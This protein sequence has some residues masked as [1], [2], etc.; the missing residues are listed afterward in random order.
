[1]QILKGPRKSV[2]RLAFSPDGRWLAVGGRQYLNLWDLPTGR[3]VHTWQLQH[4]CTGLAFSPDQRLLA[5]VD[6]EVGHDGRAEL[7]IW[8][9][10][11]PGTPVMRAADGGRFLW[12]HP[13]GSWLLVQGED[14]KL[15]RWDTSAWTPRA[16]WEGRHRREAP[17]YCQVRVSPD[18][19]FLARE[20]LQS[21]ADVG[22]HDVV[23]LYDLKS[24]ELIRTTHLT[25]FFHRLGAFLSDSRY[26]VL[27]QENHVL[28][29]D[30][31][32]G[33]VVIDRK[34]G[35]RRFDHLALSSDGRW[36]LTA[37][38]GNTVQRWDTV[39]WKER[40]TYTWS[41]GEIRCLVAA[42]DGQR[43]AAGG[44]GGGVVV[45]DLD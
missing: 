6:R 19:R 42:P 25:G 11:A 28:V 37:P 4:Y 36:A 44:S 5:A 33:K 24:G 13:D 23:E 15:T 7:L 32:E 41:V 45:W 2:F 38:A 40:Q 22:N 39:G 30:L 20:R 26:F 3:L 17:E 35:R 34:S 12:F 43:A 8:R 27:T 1:V 14:T 10:A 31:V 16:L 29:L 18:A 9:L 21:D